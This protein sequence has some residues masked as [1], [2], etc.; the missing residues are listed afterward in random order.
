MSYK[1][2]V[3][4]YFPSDEFSGSLSI[5]YRTGETVRFS[6]DYTD[7]IKNIYI[8]HGVLVHVVFENGASQMF[9]LPFLYKEW[10]EGDSCS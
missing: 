4:I 2:T 6:E 1:K 3:T 7:T 10:P 9:N 5:N 8:D